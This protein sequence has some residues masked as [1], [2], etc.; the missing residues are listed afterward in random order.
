MNR[1]HLLSIQDLQAADIERLFQSA[2]RLKRT[3]V[4]KRPL[5]GKTL[6]LLFQKPSLRTRVSFEVGMSQLGGQSLYVGPVELEQGRRESPKDLAQVLS[7]YLQGLVVRTFSHK[8]A[9]EICRWSKIPVINGLSDLH[10]PCQA[11]SDLFTVQEKLHRLRG[12][13]I[14]YVGDGN[15]VCHSLMEGSALM[16]I[17]LAIATPKGYRPDPKIVRGSLAAA[18]RSGGTLRLGND[19]G[20]AVHGAWIVYT[21]VW[22]S[23]GQESERGL[24]KKLFRPY[25]VNRRLMS[26]AEP[27]AYFMHCLPA[28]RGE[29]VTDEIMD[30]QR[31]IVYDQAENRLHVQKAILLALLK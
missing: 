8:E 3:S 21:D 2:R 15:N 16:G 20:K 18:K 22:T 7:R 6:G 12:V 30:S 17:H 14:A 13:R 29:E 9:E 19:P 10:H 25:Q 27:G 23:M 4:Q 28:H 1:R 26:R 24:R 5:S 31:S 11:L